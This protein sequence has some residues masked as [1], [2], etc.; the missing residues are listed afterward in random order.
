M[1]KTKHKT[2]K[3]QQ[4]PNCIAITSLFFVCVF[5]QN[6]HFKTD[7]SNGRPCRNAQFYGVL[8][9]L[10]VCVSVCQCQC[11]CMIQKIITTPIY[12]YH[13]HTNY[14][15]YYFIIAE[16]LLLLAYF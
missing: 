15:Y 11:V 8:I 5:L 10:S 3:P 14:Y 2:T 9:I 12:H 7:Q 6:I 1:I 4:K 16:T 13:H